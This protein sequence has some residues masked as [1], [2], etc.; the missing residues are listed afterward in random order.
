[1]VVSAAGLAAP[2][3][4]QAAP[5][6]P[7]QLSIAL[8][9]NLTQAHSNSDVSYA[10]KVTN[11]GTSPVSAELVLSTPSYVTVTHATGAKVVAH[12]ATWRITVRPGHSVSKSATARI[13][14]I[15][16]GDYRVSTLASLY[17]EEATSGVPLIRTAVA[18]TI[19]GVTDPA[20]TIKGTTPHQVRT[21]GSAGT[22]W[23]LVAG[24]P[25]LVAVLLLG[26]TLL[27]WRRRQESDGPASPAEPALELPADLAA[28]F[29]AHRRTV[30]A[31]EP[32]GG[33]TASPTARP[34]PPRPAPV[35]TGRHHASGSD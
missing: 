32:T 9:D 6:P 33:R 29:A 31:A 14:V 17:E 22:N 2:L 21:G 1:L 5:A 11:N 3:G 28:A 25:A 12:A 27:W 10:A 24:L 35:A 15:A 30:A 18:N 13:G 4:A 23:L 19:A 8:T 20:H 7:A 26:A 34:M 16:K